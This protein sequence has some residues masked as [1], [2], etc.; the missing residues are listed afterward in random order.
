MSENEGLFDPPTV[1]AMKDYRDHD[2][3]PDKS[4]HH[5]F[6]LRPVIFC[7]GHAETDRL[8]QVKRTSIWQFL[9]RTGWKNGRAV[10]AMVLIASW[11]LAA[12]RLQD[13]FA[14]KMIGFWMAIWVNTWLCGIYI[15]S[16]FQIWVTTDS[17]NSVT[18][19]CIELHV[20]H[21]MFINAIRKRLIR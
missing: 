20:F 3:S 4:P 8:G 6:W 18:T 9:S 17:G 10:L 13:E 16:T 12:V 11:I 7:F 1:L 21:H 5:G 19:L 14:Q 2:D 15:G